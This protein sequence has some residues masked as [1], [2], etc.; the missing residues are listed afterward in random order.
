MTNEHY[1]AVLED[2]ERQRDELNVAIAAL[3]RTMGIADAESAPNVVTGQVQSRRSAQIRPDQFFGMSIVDAAV[4]YLSLVRQPKPAPIIAREIKAHGLLNESKTF[5][6]TVYSILYR[7]SQRGE[8]KVVKVGNSN[9]WG[10]TDWYPKAARKAKE[11]NGAIPSSD[12]QPSE[13]EP[14]G[15]QSQS[16]A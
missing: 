5:T 12:D 3:R 8:G 13:P 10:L 11:G 14:P 2:L 15:E 1:E 16:D 7:E 4:E 9:K 6:S